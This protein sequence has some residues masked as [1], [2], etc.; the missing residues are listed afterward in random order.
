MTN[1]LAKLL[2]VAPPPDRSPYSPSDWLN[3]E[4]LL[5]TEL[6]SDY[7]AYVDRYGIGELAGFII[8]FDPFPDP[9]KWVSGINVYL[10]ADREAREHCPEYAGPIYPEPGGRLPW[11]G[12]GNGDMLWWQTT[13]PPDEWT[14]IVWETRGPDHQYFPLSSSEFLLGW[15]TGTLKVHVSTDYF[16]KRTGAKFEPIH[17]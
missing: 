1:A 3:A 12:T 11:G 6:P 17:G 7:K 5:G 2:Q 10:E 15:V 13:G 16:S 4:Q 9:E 14:V 8:V